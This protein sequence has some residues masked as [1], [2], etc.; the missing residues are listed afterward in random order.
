MRQLVGT[1]RDYE[2]FLD[3]LRDAARQM[4]FVTGARLLSGILSPAAGR[5]GL[6][7]RS[8]ARSIRA[9]FDAGARRLRGGARPRARAARWPCSASAG[10]APAS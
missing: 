2:D 6:F 8:P 9:A 10:S 5:A 4:R 1:P 7:R 3:R